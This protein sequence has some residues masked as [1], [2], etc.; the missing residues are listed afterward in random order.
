[1]S[2]RLVHRPWA[3]HICRV[4]LLLALGVWVALSVAAPQRAD[5]LKPTIFGTESSP[6]H[7]LTKA[8]GGV[9]SELAVTPSVNPPKSGNVPPVVSFHA[10]GALAALVLLLLPLMQAMR[11]RL[12]APSFHLP[13]A[14]GPIFFAIPP[15][16]T[17]IR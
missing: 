2:H 4:W 11:T 9:T 17:S 1:M 12:H 7:I 5:W 8:L 16:A 6:A 10:P 14:R 3:S 13:A 15:P